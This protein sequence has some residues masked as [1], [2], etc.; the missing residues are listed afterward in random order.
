MYFEKKL[1]ESIINGHHIEKIAPK[2]N[3]LTAFGKRNK[4]DVLLV[5]STI[6]NTSKYESFFNLF[7]RNYSFSNTSK[8]IT[9]PFNHYEKFFLNTTDGKKVLEWHKKDILKNNNDTFTAVR[10]FSKIR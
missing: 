4:E 7:Y 6:I 5:L 10:K 2:G 8:L 1:N 3:Q 9:Y